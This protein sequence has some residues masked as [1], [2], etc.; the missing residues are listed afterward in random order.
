MKKSGVLSTTLLLAVLC[1]T[2]YTKKAIYALGFKN[3]TFVGNIP[4]A[5][6]LTAHGD[7]K[8][9]EIECVHCTFNLTDTVRK[10]MQL[11]PWF[12]ENSTLISVDDKHVLTLQDNSLN[13]HGYIIKDS[14][15]FRFFEVGKV[16]LDFPFSNPNAKTVIYRAPKFN[17]ANYIIAFKGQFYNIYREEKGPQNGGLS[18]ELVSSNKLPF[19]S[20]GIKRIFHNEHVVVILL[21][22]NKI[23]LATLIGKG[24]LVII[25]RID[26]SYL[27]PE[28]AETRSSKQGLKI[29]D[30]WPIFDE[31]PVSERGMIESCF[32]RSSQSVQQSKV[33]QTVR[34]FCIKVL[35]VEPLNSQDKSSLNLCYGDLIKRKNM[36]RTKLQLSLQNGIYHAWDFQGVLIK[37]FR[38]TDGYHIEINKRRTLLH[39]SVRPTILFANQIKGIF[40]LALL[41]DNKVRVYQVFENIRKRA[42]IGENAFRDDEVHIFSAVIA[43]ISVTTLDPKLLSFIPFVYD[44][45]VFAVAAHKGLMTLYTFDFGNFKARCRP[46]R[47][48]RNF[49]SCSEQMKVSYVKLEKYLQFKEKDQAGNLK[50]WKSF[51]LTWTFYKIDIVHALT[52]ILVFAGMALMFYLLRSRSEKRTLHKY[53]IIKKTN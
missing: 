32:D 35:I 22:T 16:S 30:T 29:I 9:H 27:F 3:H 8:V 6:F 44:S 46:T 18:L 25:K 53:K 2:V 4:H 13:I 10:A 40:M 47:R 34:D 19:R 48:S 33:C 31:R 12:L 50:S 14:R 17:S 24:E 11:S 15:S 26:D 1:A 7:K 43:D 51:D 41:V 38:A 5:I 36:R 20:S 28:A 23:F 49:F 21:K 52:L 45:K 42:K 39:E 37:L